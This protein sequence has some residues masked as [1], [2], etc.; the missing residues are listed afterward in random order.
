MLQKIQYLDDSFIN[1]VGRLHRPILNR[2]MIIISSLGNGGLIW[3]MLCVPF[4]ILKT[5]RI[6]G[7]NI[8]IGLVVAH[9]SG[10]IIIKH[11][12][13]R[14]RP[15]HKLEDEELIVKRPQYYSFPSGHTTASFS[16]FVVMLCR[17]FP[18]AMPVLVLALLMGFSRIYLRVHYLTDVVCG[19]VLG[20][21]CGFLSVEIFK[22]LL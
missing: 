12:V 9:I 8:M 4:M 21:L 15:C 5:W 11:L 13:C 6:T 16:V 18:V 3:F 19:M 20:M 2:F 17:C 10:E 22:H 7:I 14:V 1:W